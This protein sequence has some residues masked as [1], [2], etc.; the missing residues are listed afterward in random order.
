M[1][2]LRSVEEAMPLALAEPEADSLGVPGRE[3]ERERGDT[4]RNNCISG[5]HMK[6]GVVLYVCVC[7][8]GDGDIEMG[9]VACVCTSTV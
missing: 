6:H 9:D 7:V 4:H 5:G 8:R 1:L 2:P 3:R